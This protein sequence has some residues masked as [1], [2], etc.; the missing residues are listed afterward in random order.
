MALSSPGT[1]HS[2]MSRYSSMA[3]PA[4]KAPR[5]PVLFASC[6]NLALVEPGRR[7]ETVSLLIGL[8]YKPEGEFLPQGGG[9]AVVVVQQIINRGRLAE[10]W[11]T[12]FNSI[13]FGEI[14]P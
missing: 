13:N 11:P 3:S 12:F 6:C 14:V 5:R 8:Q 9:V 10:R 4:S 2:L 1:R 7:A